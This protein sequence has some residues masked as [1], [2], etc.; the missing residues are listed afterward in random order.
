MATNYVKTMLAQM[1][2]TYDAVGVIVANACQ[3]LI[4]NDY[5]AQWN[6]KA[7]E[8]LYQVLIR[9]GMTSGGVSNPEVVVSEMAEANLHGM[10]YYIELFKSIGRACKHADVDL[11]K[12][13]AIY[14]QRYMKESHKDPEVVPTVDPK[15]Y[16]NI[17]KTAEEYIRGFL[18][19]RISQIGRAGRF[20]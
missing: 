12:V 16:P 19:K 15:D 1:N 9:L 20:S 3:W 11:T 14:H 13:H 2:L 6:E 10:I 18:T 4:S 7:V 17:L 8:G 5:F